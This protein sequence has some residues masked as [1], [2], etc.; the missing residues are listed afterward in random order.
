MDTPPSG[1]R[2]ALT[3]ASR[4]HHVSSVDLDRAKSALDF[5]SETRKPATTD[6]FEA[7]TIE[8]VHLRLAA[9]R[10]LRCRHVSDLPPHLDAFE[11]FARIRRTGRLLD[12]PSSLPTRPT[13]PHPSFMLPCQS[14]HHVGHP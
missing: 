4:W 11:S 14:V 10:P 7:Q 3:Q 2:F 5:A 8:T 1:L 9:T 6:G 12:S 13:S